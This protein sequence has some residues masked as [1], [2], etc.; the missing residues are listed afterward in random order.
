M[1]WRTSALI[2]WMAAIA[3]AVAAG[4]ATPSSVPATAPPSVLEPAVEDW[5]KADNGLQARVLLSLHTAG[6]TDI[7][8]RVEF[9]TQSFDALAVSIHPHLTWRL[10]DA[11]G[12]EVATTVLPGVVSGAGE[13]PEQW[14]PVQRGGMRMSIRVRPVGTYLG[15]PGTRTLALQTVKWQTGPG[16]A[17]TWA[18]APGEYALSGTLTCEKSAAGPPNQWVG[19]LDLP[20]VRFQVTPPK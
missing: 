9:Q 20:P 18:L 14:L 7:E 4:G 15:G 17:M 8:A 10:V 16:D 13:S 5:S 12:R 3:M 6:S 1:R 11:A 19:K 2:A